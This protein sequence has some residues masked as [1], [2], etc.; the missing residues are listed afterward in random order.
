MHSDLLKYGHKVAR[1]LE[2]PRARTDTPGGAAMA[3]RTCSLDDCEAPRDSNGYC[4]SHAHRW[5]RYGDPRGGGPSR[6][7][8][9]RCLIPG[10]DRRHWAQ[11]RCRKHYRQWL[12]RQAS[13]SYPLIDG[14]AWRP[15]VA[16]EGLY[17]VSDHGRVR[18]VAPASGTQAGRVLRHWPDRRGYRR[19]G[20]NRA[21]QRSVSS[22][23]RLVAAAFLGPCPPGLQVN[24][25]DGKKA[26]N[27]PS[28]LE[29]VTSAEN[30]QHAIRTGLRSSK[31]ERAAKAGRP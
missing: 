3:E 25:K 13:P 23:H 20:L 18:R 12:R 7:R 22:V 19:V 8:H 14:E 26:N 28:N 15:V 16:Y 21:D 1:R 24:H 2:Q 29:Y 27:R 5:R 30:N 11:D 6:S 10:C 17:E 9:R 4:N 31:R